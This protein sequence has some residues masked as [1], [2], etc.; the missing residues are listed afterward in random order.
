MSSDVLD[1]LRSEVARL[2]EK[3]KEQSLEIATLRAE[4]ALLR[5]STTTFD[6]C[7]AYM[8]W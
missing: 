6:P 3:Y 8:N 5:Q 7:D 2:N 4:V 1:D